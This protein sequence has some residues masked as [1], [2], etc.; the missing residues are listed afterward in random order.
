MFVR[1]C[2]FFPEKS[3]WF[4]QFDIFISQ[5]LQKLTKKDDHTRPPDIKKHR[6]KTVDFGIVYQQCS[7]SV[8]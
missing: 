1:I 4:F 8:S 3:M 7:I 6:L 2:Y 5:T